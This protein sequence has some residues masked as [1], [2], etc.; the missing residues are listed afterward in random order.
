MNRILWIIY[1]I[2]RILPA[3]SWSCEISQDKR[4]VIGAPGDTA[5]FSCTFIVAESQ[6]LTNLIINWQHGDTVVHSFY[7][8]RDQLEKQSQSYKNRT[9][10]FIDQILSGNASLSLTN[11]QPDEQGEYTC[12]ITSEQ[13][14]TSGSVTLIV[15]APYDDPELEVQYNCDNVVVTMTSTA[16]FPEPTVSWKQPRGRNVTTTQ[17]DSKGRFR[18]QSNLTINL[19]MTQ[20][21]VVEMTLKALSQHILKTITLHPQTGCCSKNADIKNLRSRPFLTVLFLAFIILLL[22]VLIKTKQ[23][24]GKNS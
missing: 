15:A 17:L 19:S 8:G 1:A 12:Y 11:V 22:S 23:D 7:H 24:E 9:H 20:T 18:V 21:V 2:S 14:T 5:I 13:E 4:V 3:H 16:G 10:L 6:L